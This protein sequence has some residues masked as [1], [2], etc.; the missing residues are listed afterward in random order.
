[1]SKTKVEIEY[2]RHW[3]LSCSEF[4]CYVETDDKNKIDG[5]SRGVARAFIGEP[6]RRFVNKVRR[7]FGGVMIEEYDKNGKCL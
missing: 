5:N 4:T 6:M 2:P 1:M 7:K 3:W